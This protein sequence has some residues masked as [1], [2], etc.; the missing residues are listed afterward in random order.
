[1]QKAHMAPPWVST[2]A[3]RV[4]LG[5]P[6]LWVAAKRVDSRYETLSLSCAAPFYLVMQQA[7]MECGVFYVSPLVLFTDA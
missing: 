5:G 3:P 6:A 1:M 2:L 7:A 4:L